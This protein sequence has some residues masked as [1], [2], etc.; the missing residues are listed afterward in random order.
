MY[1]YVYM[2]THFVFIG[3]QQ[4]L[5]SNQT[6]ITM[7]DSQQKNTGSEKKQEFTPV[8]RTKINNEDKPRRAHKIE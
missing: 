5:F 4:Y 1:F 6:K 2:H 3:L 8:M 7:S